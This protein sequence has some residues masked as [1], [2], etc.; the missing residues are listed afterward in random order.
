M[1]TNDRQGGATAYL[2][3]LD[4]AVRADPYPVFADIRATGAFRVANSP[5][6]VL[7]RYEDCAA[8]LR[9][10]AASVERALSTL[11]LETLP[12]YDGPPGAPTSEAAPMFLF[13]DPPDHTRLRRLS[14]KAFTPRVVA[15]LQPRITEIVD[16]LLDTA[17]AAGTSDVVA[18]FAY[19]L[20]VTVICE[21]LGV[22]LADEERLGHW[23]SIV[24]RSLDP[25]SRFAPQ[26]RV[27]PR[28]LQHAA[29]DMYAY[30]EDLTRIRRTSPGSDLLSELIAAEEAGDKLSH[31]ELIS[32]CALL[33]IAGHENTANLIANAVL[34]LLRNREH[35][36]ALRADPNLANA[37]VEET[38]R[39]D[40]PGQMVA[41]IAADDL[42]IGGIDIHRGDMVVLLF[43]AAHRDG[44]AFPDPDRFDPTR[45]SRHLAFGLGPHFCLGAPLARLETAIALRRFAQRIESPRLRA[46]PPPYRPHVNLRGPATMLLEI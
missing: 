14:T 15:Q 6:V 21:L 38:L 36:D 35:L 42:E 27:D 46:D 11:P 10:P 30:F 22:P 4:P 25:A 5:V 41:R 16:A 17:L 20:S 1:I 28:E 8:M 24:S 32:I 44:S 37:V 29:A 2:R 45:A 19:P 40:P 39:Y 23:S 18:D 3:L 31:N 9:H 12:A 26:F 13:L 34:A 7:S 43:A 33:L